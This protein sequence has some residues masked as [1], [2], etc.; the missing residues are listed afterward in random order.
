MAMLILQLYFVL[1]PADY[2]RYLVVWKEALEGALVRDVEPY[3]LEMGYPNPTAKVVREHVQRSMTVDE[4]TGIL[5]SLKQRHNVDTE[6]FYGQVATFLADDG[7][8]APDEWD[9]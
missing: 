5:L 1:S 7:T 4:L 9:V 3:L 6:R 2:T 8:E